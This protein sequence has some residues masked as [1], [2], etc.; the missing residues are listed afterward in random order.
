[1]TFYRCGACGQKQ[2][3]VLALHPSMSGDRSSHW[4]FLIRCR[5]CKRGF[6]TR[7]RITSSDSTVGASL[8]A[9][10]HSLAAVTTARVIVDAQTPAC[11]AEAARRY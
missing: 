4:H 10:C 5:H 8:Q 11:C 3:Y 2:A 7:D 6:F 9:V 1:M